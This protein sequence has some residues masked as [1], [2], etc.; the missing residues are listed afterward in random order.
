[1]EKQGTPEQH[2]LCPHRLVHL[3]RVRA[4]AQWVQGGP[5]SPTTCIAEDSFFVFLTSFWTKGL[6][7]QRDNGDIFAE[8]VLEF[9]YNM[10]LCDNVPFDKK[11]SAKNVVCSSET[12]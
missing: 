10:N 2:V 3:I 8:N 9:S 11:Y 5:P 12:D 6:A 7:P 1:M 4:H